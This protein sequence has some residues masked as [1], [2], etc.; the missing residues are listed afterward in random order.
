MQSAILAFL[1]SCG[2]LGGGPGV[3]SVAEPSGFLG[4][5]AHGYDINCYIIR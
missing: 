4:S 5:P 2:R 3:F 1:P